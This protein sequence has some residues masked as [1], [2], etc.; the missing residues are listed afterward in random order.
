MA[1]IAEIILHRRR[2]R[3]LHGKPTGVRTLGPVGPASAIAA[4]GSR[5]A[6]LSIQPTPAASFQEV[7]RGIGL[8]GARA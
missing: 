6:K 2:H 3:D 5:L 4:L 1:D 8:F 7:L